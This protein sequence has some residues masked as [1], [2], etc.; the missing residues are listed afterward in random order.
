MLHEA[1][2]ELEARSR[3]ISLHRS[4]KEKEKRGAASTLPA[5][6]VIASQIKVLASEINEYVQDTLESRATAHAFTFKLISCLEPEALAL[7]VLRTIINNLNQSRSAVVIK[8]GKQIADELNA[9]IALEHDFRNKLYKTMKFKLQSDLRSNRK[10]A[11]KAILDHTDSIHLKVEDN[12]FDLEKQIAAGMTLLKLTEACTD[13]FE[14]EQRSSKG[15]AIP[16]VVPTRQ[17]YEFLTEN[18]HNLALARPYFLPMISVPKDWSSL[19]NGGYYSLPTTL[20]KRGFESVLTDNESAALGP[21]LEAVNSL[22][23]VPYKLNTRIAEVARALTKQGGN[24]AGLPDFTHKLLPDKPDN[25]EWLKQNDPFKFEEYCAEAVAVHAHN[26]DVVRINECLKVV[27]LLDLVDELKAYEHVYF[28]MYADFRGRL[29][30]LP[31]NLTPAGDDLQRALLL[32][33]KPKALGQNGLKALKQHAA[34]CYGNKVDKLSFADRE[35][36]IDE[37]LA[38]L[39]ESARSPLDY[40]FWM[41]ADEPFKFLAACYELE[42][43]YALDDPT[44][45]CSALPV[46]RDGSCNGL[47]HWSAILRD[48]KT[49]AQ[50]NLYDAEKPS[51]IYATVAETLKRKLSDFKSEEAEFLKE[52]VGRSTTKKPVMTLVYGLTQFGLRESLPRNNPELFVPPYSKN[53]LQILVDAIQLAIDEDI[54]SARAGMQ[55]VRDIAKYRIEIKKNVSMTFPDKFV[56]AQAY[57]RTRV[58]YVRT[59]F[60]GTLRIKKNQPGFKPIRTNSTVIAPTKDLDL[61]QNVNAISANFIHSID[62]YHLR[63]TVKR[64]NEIGVTDIFTIHDSISVHAADVE[65]LDT[66]VRETFAQVHTVNWLELLL[67]Q[68][69]IDELVSIPMYGSWT[70]ADVLKATYFFH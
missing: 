60:N 66:V 67:K 19:T 5:K 25:V 63:K 51:D 1:Q 17:L 26:K 65:R 12:G 47:Q 64:L 38:H 70:V 32:F 39:I 57:P 8:I 15:N 23:K 24:A 27:Q 59:Y 40:E 7:I 18:E 45:Y 11:V 9:Q 52:R 21:I 56:F 48:E 4:L 55:F 62:A 43:A 50:V 49:A 53:R 2:L 69:P 28:P 44:L 41:Q 34:N 31:N 42:A 68:N 35:A 16:Y 13:L 54:T 20:V 10:K 29:Y 36:F 33:A 30:Y 22:Q 3:T 14:Y 61:R 6:A 46:A 37:K 58:Q